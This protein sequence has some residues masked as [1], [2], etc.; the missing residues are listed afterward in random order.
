MTARYSYDTERRRIRK[1]TNAGPQRTVIFV[2]DLQGQLLG[3]YDQQ[4]RAIR[5]YVWL[6]NVPVAVFMPDPADSTGAPLVYFIHTD[7]LNT[8]RVVVDREGRQRWSWMAEPFGTTASLTNP[9]GLGDFTFNLRFPGQYAD[10]E[11]GL[12]YNHWRNYDRDTGRYRES[13][14][15]GLAG[16]SF[17]TYTYGDGNPLSHIDPDGRFFFLALLGPSLGAGL[18]DLAIMGGTWWAIQPKIGPSWP[19]QPEGGDSPRD[20]YER[21]AA[22][23][24][25]DCKHLLDTCPRDLQA[26]DYRRCFR[27]CMFDKGHSG[28]LPD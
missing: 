19:T 20:K 16:K 7:H 2:Y 17:S 23:C 4:G 11:S 8:P 25:E 12:F 28:L 13:D 18:A 24:Y 26:S 3:E 27:R 9:V 1:F 10:E 5:E 14:P 22:A 21:D 15:M 6:D